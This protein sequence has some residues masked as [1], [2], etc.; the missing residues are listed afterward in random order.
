METETIKLDEGIGKCRELG[1][2]WA[3]RNNEDGK[4]YCQFEEKQ[5]CAEDEKRTIEVEWYSAWEGKSKTK[6]E[7]YVC[8]VKNG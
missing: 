4:Y 3:V 6:R 8:G 5:D 2:C 7:H 1:G